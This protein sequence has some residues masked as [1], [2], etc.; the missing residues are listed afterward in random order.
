MS[1][2][3]LPENGADELVVRKARFCSGFGKARMRIG[4]RYQSRSGINFE[5]AWFAVF[6]ESHV[7]SAQVLT[8]KNPKSFCSRLANFLFKPIGDVSWALK[9]VQWFF[10]YVPNPLCLVRINWA[11]SAWKFLKQDFHDGQDE[12]VAVSDQAN[13]ELSAGKELLDDGWLLVGLYD[14]RKLFSQASLVLHE[15]GASDPFA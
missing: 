14:P 7:H 5:N 13:R 8:I 2:Q 12:G 11:G 4:V 9:N 3:S 10:W 6:V 15:G 1:F